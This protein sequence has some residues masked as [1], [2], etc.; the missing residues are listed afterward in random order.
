M[1][2]CGH[3]FAVAPGVLIPRPETEQLVAHVVHAIETAFQEKPD[4]ASSFRV[5]DIGTGSGCIALS[6]AL[7]LPEIEVTAWDISEEALSIAQSNASSY[8]QARVT[9]ECED[10]L[11]PQT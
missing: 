8:P 7:A 11:N 9:F 5:L 6:L 1:D 4:G 2:F 10:I 3:R